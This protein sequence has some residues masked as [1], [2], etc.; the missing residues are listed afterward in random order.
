MAKYTVSYVG[1]SSA[2]STVEAASASDAKAIVESKGNSSYPHI[3]Y[4]VS[5][6]DGT[7]DLMTYGDAQKIK[8]NG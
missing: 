1:S 8:R 5:G 4:K 6:P 2:S 3:V 7:I